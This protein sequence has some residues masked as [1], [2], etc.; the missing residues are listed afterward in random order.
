MKKIILIFLLFVTFISNA[1]DNQLWFAF[2][3]SDTTY[4]GFKDINGEIK[5]EPNLVEFTTARKF[6]KIMAVIEDD[7]GN[8]KK[9]YLTKNGKKVGIDS[10]FVYDN[11]SDCESEGF[12]RFMDKKTEMVGLFDENGNIA[13]P[14]EYNALSRVENGLIVGLK[15][16][17][18]DFWDKHKESGCN[19]Y[20]WKGGKQYLINTKGQILVE[21]FDYNK[22]LDFYSLKIESKPL[23]DFI[24]QEF[25]GLN[26]KFYS[27]IDFEKEFYKKMK[28][29][30]STD[31]TKD[32]LSSTCFDSIYFWK[33][34][35]GWI[36]ESNA[37]FI[38]R[39][40]EIVKERLLQ[41]RKPNSDYNIFVQGLNPYIHEG[42]T[43]A[44]YF[45][46]CG[47]ARESK[48]PVMNIVINNKIN[49]ELVQDH[50]DFLKTDKGYELISMT[51][52]TRKI[53]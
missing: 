27:L 3:D 22:Y 42:N 20:S 7:N 6:D 32:E 48:Y 24:R 16:A 4:I 14:A 50:F 41:L 18:K 53:E 10:L 2:W 44:K 39:N 47:E 31:F 35:Q 37:S 17:K 11:A 38:N 9:Y 12:I 25:K 21:N 52:N 34:G 15:G 26:G 28:I 8:Y 1:Q 13:I 49:G 46:N 40:F 19:H 29:L 5:I 33:D 30:I 45:N 43:F 51:I 36:S 23:N